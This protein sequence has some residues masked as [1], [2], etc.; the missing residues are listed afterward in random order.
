MKSDAGSE[1]EPDRAQGD[2]GADRRA[3]GGAERG[4][5]ARLARA[6]VAVHVAAEAGQVVL[7]GRRRIEGIDFVAREAEAEQRLQRG[8]RLDALVEVTADDARHSHPPPDLEAAHFDARHA[9]ERSVLRDRAPRDA[10]ALLRQQRRE[11]RI[12]QR[13][14]RIF[15]RDELLQQRAHRR[16]RGRRRRLRWRACREKKCLNSNTPRGVAMYLLLV[17][18]HTVDSCRLDCAGDLLQRERL[19]RDFAVLEEAAAGARRSLRRRAG[20]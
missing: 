13:T 1:P 3:D 17:T 5:A 18:R 2:Q 19:H 6:G 15:G 10:Q 11:L 9:H 4:A 8:V 16:R 12:R 14:R 20:W 7:A